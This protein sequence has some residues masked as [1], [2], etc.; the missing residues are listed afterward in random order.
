MRPSARGG[1]EMTKREKSLTLSEIITGTRRKAGG[2]IEIKE[3]KLITG[4]RALHLTG[5]TS[6]YHPS[7]L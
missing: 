1:E 6:Y 7:M 4:T 2:Q 3:E 5:P